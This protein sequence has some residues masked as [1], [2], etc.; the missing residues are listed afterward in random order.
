MKKL[1][2][3]IIG[4]WLFKVLII[5]AIGIA[6]VATGITSIALS[7]SN[8]TLIEESSDTYVDNLRYQTNFGTDPIIVVIEN[9]D[10]DSLLSYSSLSILNDLNNNV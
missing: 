2:N 9:T 10:V 3:K 5:I 4:K 7:T 1:L 6:A 8:E